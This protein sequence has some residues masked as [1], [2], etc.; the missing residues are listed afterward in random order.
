MN[1]SRSRAN[2]GILKKAKFAFFFLLDVITV[3][4]Q[5]IL[6]RGLSINIISFDVLARPEV[7]IGHAVDFVVVVQQPLQQL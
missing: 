6:G 4:Q 2:F 1:Q 3:F 7:E 5:H